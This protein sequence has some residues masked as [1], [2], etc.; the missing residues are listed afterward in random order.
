MSTLFA[1][2][3]I[4]IITN[5]GTYVFAHDIGYKRGYKEGVTDT[6]ETNERK[7]S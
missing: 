2:F 6:L 5:I 4:I 7:P 3:F 1:V